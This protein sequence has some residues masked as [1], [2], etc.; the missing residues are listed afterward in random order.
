[1]NG[2]CSKTPGPLLSLQNSVGLP[3]VYTADA[4]LPSAI[5]SLSFS[6]SFSVSPIRNDV[7]AGRRVPGAERDSRTNV[8]EFSPKKAPGFHRGLKFASG[9]SAAS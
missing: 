7:G 5:I 9:L 2:L 1:V 8:P 6:F 3:R 4:S